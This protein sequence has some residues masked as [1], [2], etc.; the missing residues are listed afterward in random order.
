MLYFDSVLHTWMIKV[1]LP[2]ACRRPLTFIQHA[3]ETFLTDDFDTTARLSVGR[4]LA[5]CSDDLLTHGGLP[6]HHTTVSVLTNLT[7][8]R[9][10]ID[11][12]RSAISTISKIDMTRSV[13]AI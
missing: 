11:R 10:K 2:P 5:K 8:N 1:K 12:T 9:Q 3:V 13:T 7:S 4:I 6:Q